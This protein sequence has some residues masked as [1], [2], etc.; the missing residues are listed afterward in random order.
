MIAFGSVYPYAQNP[1]AGDQFSLLVSTYPIRFIYGPNLQMT[2][3]F[4]NGHQVTLHYQFH[5][6]DFF[7]VRQSSDVLGLTAIPRLLDADGYTLYASYLFPATINQT[8][9]GPKLGI[10]KVDGYM[11]EDEGYPDLINQTNLYALINWVYR[12]KNQGLFMELYAHAGLVF[13]KRQ[14]SEYRNNQRYYSNQ[15][16][17]YVLPHI[18]VGCSVGFGI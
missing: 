5:Q 10:K 11:D 9:L 18:L 4:S 8:W 14:E 7:S 17:W 3:L 1:P 16:P 12:T 13:I 2:G 6:R 15:Y